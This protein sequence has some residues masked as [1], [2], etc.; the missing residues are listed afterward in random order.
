MNRIIYV[1]YVLRTKLDAKEPPQET[2]F[3]QVRSHRADP[4]STLSKYLVSQNVAGARFAF[5]DF[6]TGLKGAFK[7]FI[8]KTSRCF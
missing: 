3:K 7:N 6:L 1:Y 2:W 8:I 5:A 4:L